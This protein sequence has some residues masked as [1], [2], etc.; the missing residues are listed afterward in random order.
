MPE[1][2]DNKKHEIRTERDYLRPPQKAALLM[3]IK[4]YAGKTR[5]NAVS[6]LWHQDRKIIQGMIFHLI[7]ERG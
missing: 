3:S 4:L 7:I 1:G 5:L 6:V 2:K